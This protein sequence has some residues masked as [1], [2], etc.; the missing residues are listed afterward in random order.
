[1]SVDACIKLSI[2]GVAISNIFFRHFQKIHSK[3]LILLTQPITATWYLSRFADF[4]KIDDPSLNVLLDFV[5]TYSAKPLN[6]SACNPGFSQQAS[7]DVK[8]LACGC[9]SGCSLSEPAGTINDVL[10]LSVN[11][12]AEPQI[13]Q[14][15]LENS[16][17]G[18]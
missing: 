5:I 3:S 16:C 7:S 18:C 15:D 1:M 10:V 17:V 13:A 9:I 14:K 2:I 6:L 4:G 11:G 8:I 12:T